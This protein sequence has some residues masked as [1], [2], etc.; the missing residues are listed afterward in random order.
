MAYSSYAV[1]EAAPVLFERPTEFLRSQRR[2]ISPPALP[3]RT[4]YASPVRAAP[5][6]L[7]F[8]SGA[9]VGLGGPQLVLGVGPVTRDPM[10]PAGQ[11]VPADKLGH[12]ALQLRG[13]RT[14]TL[15]RAGVALAALGASIE[16]IAGTA[17]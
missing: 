12:F 15:E 8:D 3:R 10:D 16:I 9:N 1:G 13:S 14:A 4:R 7:E 11:T 2:C 5:P 17:R 6:T